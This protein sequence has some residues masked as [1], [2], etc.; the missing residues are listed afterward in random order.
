[1]AAKPFHLK[2][3]P[4]GAWRVAWLGD[5]AFRN[6]YQSYSQP[7]IRV[8]LAPSEPTAPAKL[9]EVQL[10][11]GALMAAPMDSLWIDGTKLEAAVPPDLIRATVEID[12]TSLTPI[13]AG[14]SDEQLFGSESF[15]LPF[16]QHS[17]H[18]EHT[19]SWCLHGKAGD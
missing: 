15:F 5:V 19:E 10:A 6:R 7:S 1:M 14:M 2:S 18:R 8:T 17:F 9:V 3:F 12:T 4:E 13:K 11:V 16:W